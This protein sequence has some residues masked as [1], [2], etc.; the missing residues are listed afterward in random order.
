M[1]DRYMRM[2]LRTSAVFNLLG[3]L[4][5]AMPDSLGQIA[6]LPS[7]V[8]RVHTALLV[9]FVLLFGGAY[10]WVANQPRLNRPFI[11]FGALGK[12][13]AFGVVALFFALGEAPARSVMAFSGDLGFAAVF[14]W[15]LLA[16]RHDAA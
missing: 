4:M 2:A 3:A 15:W 10:A 11:A 5:F 12:A 14:T 1:N 7:P 13:A 8:P 6:A 9:M 16:T